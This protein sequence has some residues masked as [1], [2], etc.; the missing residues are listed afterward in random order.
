MTGRSAVADGART[1]V[2]RAS[3]AQRRR[4]VRVV[5]RAGSVDRVARAGDALESVVVSVD[6]ARVAMAAVRAGVT[7]IVEGAGIG[8]VRSG[9]RGNP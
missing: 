7:E 6:R 1:G 5:R 4:V 8:T 3:A 9:S 2:R